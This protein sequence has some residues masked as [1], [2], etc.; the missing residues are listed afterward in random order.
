MD[1]KILIA[2]DHAIFR[3]GLRS[4]FE[5]E[6]GITVVGE[7]GNG[8]EA[9]ELSRQL[10]PDVVLMDITMPGL[11]GIEATRRI[12]AEGG[13]VRVLAF[14]MESD[15]RFVVEVLE[16][17]ASGYVLKEAHFKELIAAVRAV[18]GGDKYF[19]PEIA[20]LIIKDYLK[21]IPEGL[22]LT[23]DSLTPREREMLQ[24]IADGSN[25]KE[26][27]AR[28]D[29]SVKTVEVHRHNIT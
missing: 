1:L 26:I 22:P 21:K 13:E 3:E 7:A 23:H 20:E 8:N 28:Y 17:G 10:R 18:A 4:L 6:Q 15:R 5:K 24:L 27:A 11:N 16:A 2:D 9:V 29:I 12:V 19:C 14:S 25:A